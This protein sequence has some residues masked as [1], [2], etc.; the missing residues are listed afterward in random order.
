[1]GFGLVQEACLE[2]YLTRAS[3]TPQATIKIRQDVKKIIANST[4][5]EWYAIDQQ[6]PVYLLSSITKGI[7]TRVVI[8]ATTTVAWST[9]ERIFSYMT[10]AH[11]IN[12]RITLTNMKKGNKSITEQ[13]TKS[14]ALANRFF[15]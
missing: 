8:S 15:R 5:E 1:M 7:I 3:S 14:R 6:V 11:F 9:I 2:G 10:R 13:V 12:I 4:Y